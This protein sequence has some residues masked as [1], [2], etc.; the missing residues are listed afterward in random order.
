[1]GRVP[2][3]LLLA[4][5]LGLVACGPEVDLRHWPLPPW[6]STTQSAIFVVFATPPPN[7]YAESPTLIASAVDQYG[8]PALPLEFSSEPNLVV[9]ALAYDLELRNLDL[10]PG[11]VPRPNGDELTRLLPTPTAIHRFREPDG[12]WRPAELDPELVSRR[13]R[14][15]DP[16]RCVTQGGCPE[17][18]LSLCGTCTRPMIP[19]P[20]A[21]PSPPET[22]R[23]SG[24]RVASSTTTL[25]AWPVGF[26]EPRPPPVTCPPGEFQPG[27]LDRCLAL[28]PA[29][30]GRFAS[31]LPAG[32]VR[33]VDPQEPAGG[34]GSA[35][36]PFRTLAEALASPP[37]GLVVALA[38]GAYPGAVHLPTGVTL[39]GVGA[40]RTR[41]GD[42]TAEGLT[43]NGVGTLQGLRVEGAPALRVPAGAEL[44]LVAVAA[45]G[46]TGVEVQGNLHAEGL[47]VEASPDWAMELA[48]GHADLKRV[49]IT[50][51]GKG[52]LVDGGRAELV[53]E[54][55]EVMGPVGAAILVRAGASATLQRVVV[56]GAVS[57]VVVQ[58]AAAE[59][60]DLLVRDGAPPVGGHSFASTFGAQV[61]G[62]RWQLLRSTGASVVVTGTSTAELADLR[63][64]DAGS[65]LILVDRGGTLTGERVW[66]RRGTN[67]LHANA[68]S[69]LVLSDLELID[70]P[71][72]PTHALFI[73]DAEVEL[74]RA[75]IVGGSGSGIT[76]AMIQPRLT[77]SDLELQGPGDAA[78]NLVGT[79]DHVIGER[80]AILDSNGP[81]VVGT[82]DTTFEAKELWVTRARDRTGRRN[83]ALSF[84]SGSAVDLERFLVEECPVTALDLEGT[85]ERPAP[86]SL[87]YGW[88]RNNAIGLSFRMEVAAF[89][90]T[91]SQVV[92]EDNT[93]AVQVP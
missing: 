84:T 32:P 1:M 40:A 82:G 58:S 57:G 42:A 41:I 12:A 68:Q 52:I 72:D 22:P 63:L 93:Q 26:C 25:V 17:E 73:I 31:G 67:G 37:A 79:G 15:I 20:P 46:S 66:G 19:A 3:W 91:L 62:R 39:V 85:S 56:T 4:G 43:A 87:R 71:L 59:I 11:A 77:F 60:D 83:A 28:G 14:A 78:L 89:A 88:I 38:A 5:P 64:E 54:E 49:R 45:A 10:T 55:L 16:F 6:P 36:R 21:P 44:S 47:L 35:T 23:H 92:F 29:A 65:W 53:A 8:L 7:G 50:G 81:A 13:I 34:D 76:T 61:R 33:Y 75:R 69:R 90:D 2:R 24:C 80:V 74:T 9:D 48:G 30:P 51:G 18:G 70:T 86:K 27:N